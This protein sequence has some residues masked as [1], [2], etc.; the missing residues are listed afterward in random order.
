MI[1]T[2]G[3]VLGGAMTIG[4]N[5]WLTEAM[6][7]PKIGLLYVPIGMGVLWIIGQLAVLGPA[8]RACGVPPA[9]ATRTV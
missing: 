7:L 9:V 6:S 1:T 4:F 3:V 5:V 8:R 2:F